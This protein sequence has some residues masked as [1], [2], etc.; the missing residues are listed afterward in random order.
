M[1]NVVTYFITVF[2]FFIN[3]GD[4]ASLEKLGLLF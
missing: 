3:M 1:V 4:W 2:L